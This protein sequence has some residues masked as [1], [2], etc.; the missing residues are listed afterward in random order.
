MVGWPAGQL[1]GGLLVGG[2]LVTGRWSVGWWAPEGG[3]WFPSSA[4]RTH[5]D[6]CLAGRT[7]VAAERVLAHGEAGGSVAEFGDGPRQLIPGDAGGADVAGTVG[8]G[9]RPV[10]LDGEGAAVVVGGQ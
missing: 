3:W 9:F 10:E 6:D 7:K 4:T 5:P 1:V 8:P 2:W